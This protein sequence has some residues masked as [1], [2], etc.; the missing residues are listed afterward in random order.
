MIRLRIGKFWG[1]GKRADREFADDRASLLHLLE[2]LFILL[3]VNHINAAAQNANRRAGR[4]TEGPFV[5]AGVN[6]SSQ[7][8]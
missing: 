3:R 5:C 2:N 1:A 7:A 4:R 8:A 6:S